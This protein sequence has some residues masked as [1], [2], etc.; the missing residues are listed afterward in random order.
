LLEEIQPAQVHV[1]IDGR[2]ERSGDASLA[3]LIEEHGYESLRPS[4]VA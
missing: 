4:G 2:I 1:L 3:Q